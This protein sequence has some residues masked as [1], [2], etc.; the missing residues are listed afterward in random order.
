MKIKVCGMR[1]PSNIEA[2]VD[3]GIDYVGFIF[4]EKSPRCIQKVPQISNFGNTKKVGV[5][6]NSSLE[7]ILGKIKEYQL[8]L[9]QLHG[10][11]SVAF[12]QQLQET[13]AGYPTNR[14]STV[15]I[16]KVF[17]LDNH[18]D[19][20]E[21]DAFVPYTNYFLFDTKTQHLGGSGVR[22]DWSILEKYP[23]KV[24]F[25]LSGG[26]DLPHTEAIL[27][28]KHLPIHALDINSRF[29]LKAG[30]KDI[31]KIKKFIDMLQNS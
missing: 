13:I 24:P 18:F 25:F 23:L 22:F 3:L 29:E 30:L 2:L 6:V 26:I 19:F 12:C 28:L 20:T 1:E 5:F 27:A 15:Q 8:D 10:G 11:E 7:F 31:D 21:L 9:I 17:L 14:Q 16:I 4:Y